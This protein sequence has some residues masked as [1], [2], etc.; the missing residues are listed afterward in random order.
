MTLKEIE[1]LKNIANDLKLHANKN[2][3]KLEE[4]I[5]EQEE[6]RRRKIEISSKAVY[7]GRAKNKLYGRSKKQLAYKKQVKIKENEF[8]DLD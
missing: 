4:F 8:I 5:K 2:A 3:S 7:A 6:K 1:F